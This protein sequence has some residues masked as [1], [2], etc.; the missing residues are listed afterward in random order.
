LPRVLV[1]QGA[2]ITEGREHYDQAIYEPAEHRALAT[3]FGQDV[4]VV[5]PYR[6]SSALWGLALLM[7][8]A[9]TYSTP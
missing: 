6:R 3:R 7:P 4:G 9:R 5:I 8:L 2:N 1:E